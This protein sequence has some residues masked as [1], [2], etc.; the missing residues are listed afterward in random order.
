MNRSPDYREQGGPAARERAHS[1]SAWSEALRTACTVI[2]DT[3]T[4]TAWHR[5]ARTALVE[6]TQQS[7]ET[8]QG[9]SAASFTCSFSFLEFLIYKMP[10]PLP[11]L[12]VQ[13]TNCGKISPVF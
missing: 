3:K 1:G 2:P 9:H 10:A 13:T 7:P 11:H 4:M 12:K 5:K 6:R 8:F